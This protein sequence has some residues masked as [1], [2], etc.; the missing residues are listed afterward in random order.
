MKMKKTSVTPCHNLNF[1]LSPLDHFSTSDQWPHFS[2]VLRGN[3]LFT[4]L[5][6]PPSIFLCNCSVSK[7][8]LV[9]RRGLSVVFIAVFLQPRLT[10]A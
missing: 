3:N 8:T 10:V 7:M 4:L 5:Q 9:F 2:L 1:F 6:L